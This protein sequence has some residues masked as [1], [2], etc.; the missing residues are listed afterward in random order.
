MIR[1]KTFIFALY[2]AGLSAAVFGVSALLGAGGHASAHVNT[3]SANGA[4]AE[5]QVSHVHGASNIYTV[6]V[7]AGFV[8]TPSQLTVNAGDTV[9]W[10]NLGGLHTVDS[11]NGSLDS[12]PSV[13]SY[14]VTF[15]QT[16]VYD[17]FCVPHQFI[18]M[19]GRITVIDAPGTTATPTATPG[20]TATPSPVPT[21]GPGD[22]VTSVFTS[23][24]DNTLFSES[25]AESNGAGDAFYIGKTQTDLRRGLV[26]FDL[27]AIPPGSVILS[28]TVQLNSLRDNNGAQTAY[29]HRASAAWGE[30]ASTSTGGTGAPAQQGEAT[31]SHRFY[32]STI[33][34]T[35]GGDFAVTESTSVT[36]ALS[37]TYTAP[38]SPQLVAD[39]QAWVNSP[40]SNNGWFVIGNE[41][42]TQSAKQI[43]SREHPSAAKRPVLQVT[44]RAAERA[45]TSLS[46][47]FGPETTATVTSGTGFGAFVLDATN[48]KLF[49][50]IVY[51]GLGSAETNAHFHAFVPPATSGPPIAGQPLSANGSPKSG[52]WNFGSEAIQD[53]ILNGQVY[54]N[55]HSTNFPAGEIRGT[56]LNAAPCRQINLPIVVRQ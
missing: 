50:T 26:A 52:V 17:Y 37:G 2:I 10:T 16:G 56:L 47:T 46:L 23:T 12:P 18:G 11:T 51:T 5:A 9:V 55:I 53:Q 44:Y 28:A 15:S 45:C 4:P 1:S 22:P 7:G 49:Y 30:G 33:W 41:G 14:S 43:A 25:G 40:A 34:S 6:T 35:P 32:S 54:V 39:V 21:R 29:L 24:K 19:I 27:G 42:Q 36:I 31:W 48:N 8:F 3:G 20:A 13:S 38:S